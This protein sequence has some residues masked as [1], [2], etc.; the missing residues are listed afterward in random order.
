[1]AANDEVDDVDVAKSKVVAIAELMAASEAND[2][3]AAAAGKV[4]AVA[5][6]PLAPTATPHAHGQNSSHV[7]M[8]LSSLASWAYGA[9]FWIQFFGGDK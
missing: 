7:P 8:G 5:V 1:M 2:A 6:A 4:G 3:V 9:R